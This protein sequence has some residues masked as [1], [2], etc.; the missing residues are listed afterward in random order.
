MGFSFA[1]IA[2]LAVVAVAG[3]AL[4]LLFAPWLVLGAV[5]WALAP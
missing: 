5:V 1:R 4:T 2:G 3:L